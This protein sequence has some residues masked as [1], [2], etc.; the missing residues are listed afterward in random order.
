MR[1]FGQTGLFTDP[2]LSGSGGGDDKRL[3]KFAGMLVVAGLLFP[4]VAN[5]YNAPVQGA[6]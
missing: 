6:R 4:V 2:Y 1:N 5:W 3:L